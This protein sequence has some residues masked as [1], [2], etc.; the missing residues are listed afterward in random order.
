MIGSPTDGQ[1]IVVGQDESG[2]QSVFVV[3][4]PTA[5]A[6][7]QPPKATP[8][9]TPTDVA[10]TESPATASTAPSSTPSPV[11]TPAP[12][13]DETATVGPTTEPTQTAEP[14]QTPEPTPVVTPVPTPSGLETPSAEP[15]V[16]LN[17]AIASGVSV[18]GESAAFSADGQWFAFTARPADGSG[19]PDIYVWRVG[20]AQATRLTTN[21]LSV[22]ASWDGDRIIG[23]GP[24]TD[25]LDRRRYQPVSFRL[26]PASGERT[27]VS[28]GLWR[29]ALD[30]TGT[31]A[32]AW[33]GS[34][35]VPVSDPV[36]MTAGRGDFRIVRWPSDGNASN[37]AGDPIPGRLGADR[38]LRR[39]LG[40]DRARGWR[41]GSP[42]AR[43]R[44]SAG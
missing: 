32:V 4:L 11:E 27:V 1:A 25:D 22:F 39:P 9:P 35:R 12:T 21:G 17:L 33:D 41:S 29:P 7:T 44:R 10:S 2:R 16:A 31:F 26:D 5:R 36:D 3:S 14:T 37:T 18:V 8:T 19:G 42:S 43:T 13:P 38:R 15:T 20:D 23:S 24:E 28:T 40:R 6:E 34:V 30:P